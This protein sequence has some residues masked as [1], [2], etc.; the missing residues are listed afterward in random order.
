MAVLACEKIR[1]GSVGL[2][3]DKEWQ[4]WLVGR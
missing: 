1:N 2:R 4:C 3:E